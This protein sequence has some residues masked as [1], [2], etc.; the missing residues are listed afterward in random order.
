MHGKE[1]FRNF[2]SRTISVPATAGLA[3]AIGFAL[4]VMF[5]QSAQAQTFNVIH[6]FTGG[7]DGFD[8]RTGLTMDRAGNL[9]GTTAGWDAP[10][11]D[12]SRGTVCGTVFEVSPSGVLSTLHKFAGG[13]AGEEPDARV[14]FGPDGNLYGTTQYGGGCLWSGG[15]GT[16]FKLTPPARVPRTAVAG[17]EKNG[18]LSLL[19]L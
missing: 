19:S 18:P 6:N 3:M 2:L 16:V 11:N 5:A 8:P 9:Y 17:W 12:C 4:M 1:H 15:C 13:S 14:L 7:G 10:G